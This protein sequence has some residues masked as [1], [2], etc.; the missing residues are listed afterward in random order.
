MNLTPNFARKWL[1]TLLLPAAVIAGVW[2]QAETMAEPKPAVTPSEAIKTLSHAPLAPGTND[3]RIAY[4]VASMLGSIHYSQHPLDNDYSGKFYDRYLESLDPQHLHF[5]QEDLA[6]FEHY[7]F[8][9]DEMTLNAK[10]TADVTPA[11]EIFNRFLERLEQRAL[12]A[13]ELLKTQPF[14]FNTTERMQLNRKDAPYP[15]DL[16]DAKKL[17]EQRLR[18]EYLQEKLAKAGAKKKPVSAAP[19]QTTTATEAKKDVK[20]K[21]DAEDI[22]ETLNRRYARNIRL[23][24]EW[25]NEDVR[26]VYLTALSHVYDPHSD[27]MNKAVSDNFA[28]GMN[29]ILFGIGAE[30]RSEDGFCTINRLISGGPAEKSKK[31]KEK[32]RIVGVA[33][34]DGPSVDVVEMSLN[35]V[36]QMIRG[37]KGTEVNLTVQPANTDASERY[38]IKLVRDEIKLEDQAA[39]AKIIEIPNGTATPQRLGVIDLPSFYFPMQSRPALFTPDGQPIYGRYTSVDVAAYLKKFKEE[40]VSGVILDLRRNGGGSLE[41]AIKLTGLFI[42]DGPVVQVRNFNGGVMVDNDEDSGVAYDG[43]LAVLTS[44]FSASASEILAGALQDYGRALIIG[45]KATHGK[46]TVQNLNDL[47]PIPWLQTLST[48]DPGELK[49]TIRKFYRASGASTQL[50]G[51]LPDIV[52][53]SILS[54]SE[55]IGESALENP[56]PWDTIKSAKYDKVNLVEP[57]LGDLLRRSGTRTSTN[58]DYTYIREDIE[59]FR[60]NQMDKTVSLNEA[61]RLKEKDE[62]EARQKARDKERLARKEADLK[63]YE[64]GLKQLVLP[65]LPPPMQKTNTQTVTLADGSKAT[66]SIFKVNGVTVT[67][68]ATLTATTTGHSD[69]GL[70]ELPEAD[71]VPPATDPALEEAERILSDYI[72]LLSQKGL[73]AAKA[74]PT[75]TA[76][77]LGR[78]E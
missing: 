57:Y 18:Y 76:A 63:I 13:E 60:K 21:T 33:Q 1:L 14:E 34:A 17:W 73:A 74:T 66:L 67:N 26:Q 6:Q 41:E 55:D 4:V 5:T 2:A 37:P 38:T 44:R 59:L 58:Q 29:N 56:L 32:D 8:Q 70:D 47:S 28:I 61:S 25:D 24:K 19:T 48:N 27:Y 45:D 75:P 54:Y 20:K 23:F 42:K 71:E 30:L 31:I 77:A 7:R 10:R 62:A 22:V 12:F 9:L 3:G 15:K 72:E 51:V 50:K 49:V 16:A 69:L 11:F 65:G 40:K 35:K 36:V 68:T 53:P 46:G 39:K 43:P 64:L 52:L 78:P